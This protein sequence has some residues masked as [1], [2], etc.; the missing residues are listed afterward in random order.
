MYDDI[1]NVLQTDPEFDLDIKEDV[2][3]ECSKFGPV[4]HIYVDKYAVPILIYICI[5]ACSANVADKEMGVGK[6][7]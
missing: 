4:K 2:E 6:L 1:I 3:E 5:C 7:Y